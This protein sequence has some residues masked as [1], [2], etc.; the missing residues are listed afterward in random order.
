MLTLASSD[1]PQ[2]RLSKSENKESSSSSDKDD[3]GLFIVARSPMND[4]FPVRF[5]TWFSTTPQ[6]EQ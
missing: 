4:Y 2:S 5:S 6:V 3:L 1:D